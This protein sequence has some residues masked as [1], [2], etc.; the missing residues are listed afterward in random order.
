[1]NE[2]INY[3]FTIPYKATLD[4]FHAIKEEKS[5]LHPR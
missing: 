1:M 3:K 2:M 5:K 4:Y